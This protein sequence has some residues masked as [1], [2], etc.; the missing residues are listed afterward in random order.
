[1]PNVFHSLH[2][3]SKLALRMVKVHLLC[4]SRQ[5]MLS[6]LS[7]GGSRCAGRTASRSLLLR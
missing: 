7:Y 1:M 3:D 6:F 5:Y 2:V 4:K